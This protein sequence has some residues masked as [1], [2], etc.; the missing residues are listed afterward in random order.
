MKNFLPKQY[1]KTTKL[2]INHNYLYE[3]FADYTKIFKEIEKVVKRGDYTLGQKVDEF[4]KNIAKRTGAKFVIGVGNGTDALFLSLKALNI[5][6]G[7]EVITVPYTFVATVG[8][9]AT[10]G[11]KPVFVDIKRDY[12]IDEKKIESAITKKTKAIMPVHWAGRPCEL[13]KI[14]SIAKKYNLKIIQDG[15]QTIDSR[16]KNK[17]LVNFGD[18]CTY[19][20]HPLKNLNIWGD[21]GFVATNNKKIA[22]KIFLLRNHGLV[23][24]NNSKIFGYNSRLDTLQAVVANYKLKNKMNNITKKRIKNASLFDKAFKHNLN[25]KTVKRFKHLKEVYHLYHINVKRRNEL[26]QHLIKNGVD[27]KVH[28]PIP[29]HLQDAAKY[30]KYKRGDF[31]I[32]EQMANTSMSLPVHEFIKEKDI[33]YVVNLI[34]NFF[35]KKN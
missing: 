23:N 28:Y 13:D 1:K 11:A 35:K 29:I 34:N 30:L 33:K 21:G 9:I 20:M 4:E 18:V 7:D 12:N 14:K 15:S 19:S 2:K 22:D 6:K 26:Q 32:A 3:Q 17:Q 31:P 5:G 10:A 16:F 8:S 24:R 27:A 25:V